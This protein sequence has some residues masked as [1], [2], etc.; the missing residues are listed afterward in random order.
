MSIAKTPRPPYYAVIFSN[1]LSSDVDGYTET[2]ERML[3]LAAEQ[4]GFLGFE[5]VR[6]GMGIT[7]S[8]WRD[9]EAIKL[10]KANSE[11]QVAQK[12]GKEKWYSQFVTRIAKVERDYSLGLDEQ[13]DFK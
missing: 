5:S 9:L 8:Y 12:T 10:W 2:A 7:V 11:H 13:A 3:E 1:Y 4:P 6:D